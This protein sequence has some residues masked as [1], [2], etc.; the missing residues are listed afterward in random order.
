MTSFLDG[1]ERID[2]TIMTSV[3]TLFARLNVFPFIIDDETISA[4]SAYNRSLSSG[5]DKYFEF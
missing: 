2:V 5:S 4:P 1:V 3:V